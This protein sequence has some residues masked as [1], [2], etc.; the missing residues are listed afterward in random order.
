MAVENLLAGL[1]GERIP[2]CANPQVYG[3]SRA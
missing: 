3:T 1:A 2:N